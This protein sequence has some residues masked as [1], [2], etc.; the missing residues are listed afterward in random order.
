[1]ALL[2]EEDNDQND[3]D[4][5]NNK[6]QKTEPLKAHLTDE[7]ITIAKTMALHCI[8]LITLKRCFSSH[9]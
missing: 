8:V 7:V 9:N 4:E 1:M 5:R 3:K 2:L 6:A